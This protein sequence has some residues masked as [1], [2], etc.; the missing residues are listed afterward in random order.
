MELINWD[1][2]DS[3][4]LLNPKH[5]LKREEIIKAL[6][7][8]SDDLQGCVWLSTSGS[9]ETKLVALKKQAL[10]TSANSVNNFL[11]VTLSDVWINPLP[12]FHVGGLGMT[13]RAYLSHTKHFFYNEKW[14]PHNYCHFLEEK[15]GTLS[16][17]V[18]TQIYDIV[19]MNL[20]APQNL[21]AVVVGGGAL[22]PSIFLKAKRLG[23]P[24]LPSYGL[25]ECS[26]QVATA[27]LSHLFES[28]LP[29][30]EI[31][32]HIEL[33][34]STE[35][36]IC[37]KSPAL[38]TA[39]ARLKEGKLH[40]LPAINNGWYV[41]EDLGE[42]IGKYLKVYGRKGDFIKVGGENVDFGRLEQVLMDTKFQ[43]NFH[44][45]V[46]LGAIPDDRL[47][48]AIHLFTTDKDYD[49]LQTE[50]N[51]HVMPFEKIRKVHCVTEIPRSPL[52]KIL[53]NELL[54]L[55]K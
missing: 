13:A 32:P 33:K 23:W 26:S 18:P 5:P 38:F 14:N 50:F 28:R 24:L 51:R 53:R 39:C 19:T 6:K 8:T 3:F 21:R 29:E 12:L 20:S 27:N 35:G 16:A 15:K 2:K 25:T 34:I 47:G 41:T 36:Q 10:L 43:L 1:S 9:T 55:I 49:L 4:I 45:D 42:V 40:F 7:E 11:N 22:N 44:A 30:L 46:A 52:N 31:L 48:H 54:K 37:I 17:L